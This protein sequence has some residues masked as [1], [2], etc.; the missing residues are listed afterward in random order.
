M[1]CAPPRTWLFACWKPGAI[2]PYLLKNC[3]PCPT[4]PT[5][6][7]SIPH[8]PRWRTGRAGSPG[9][10]YGPGSPDTYPGWYAVPRS[11]ATTY[12][13]STE[14]AVPIMPRLSEGRALSPL[15]ID[16]FPSGFAWLTLALPVGAI[17]MKIGS[18]PLNF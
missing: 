17:S 14:E 15:M 1:A 13:K 10:R 12:W 18:S 3:S 9:D 4:A 7:V 11:V 8:N 5:R 2:S 16:P 6:S